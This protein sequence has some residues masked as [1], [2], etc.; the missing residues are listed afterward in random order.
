MVAER[1]RSSQNLIQTLKGS[2]ISR[3]QKSTIVICLLPAKL[4]R[5]KSSLGTASRRHARVKHRGELI[6]NP[7]IFSES[8]LSYSALGFFD[9]PKTLCK[10]TCCRAALLHLLLRPTIPV[11]SLPTDLTSSSFPSGFQPHSTQQWH[12]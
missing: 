8:S 10:E 11:Y 12:P 2:Q 3:G 7:Q 6:G 9:E 5:N 4:Q 1:R